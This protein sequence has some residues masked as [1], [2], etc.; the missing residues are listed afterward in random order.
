M[1]RHNPHCFGEH[2]AL[3]LE[4]LLAHRVP[5]AR[6]P[7]EVETVYPFADQIWLVAVWNFLAQF[8]SGGIQHSVQF[9]AI[10]RQSPNSRYGVSL[11]RTTVV[12]E[13]CRGQASAQ[14][15]S[16]RTFCPLYVKIFFP[17]YRFVRNRPCLLFGG[18]ERTRTSTS[19]ETRS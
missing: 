17:E 11:L 9:G 12:Q 14:K 19:C 4:L 16:N 10:H 7:Y 1:I 6:V 2:P 3:H 18:Q 13:T 15:L 5:V 8:T